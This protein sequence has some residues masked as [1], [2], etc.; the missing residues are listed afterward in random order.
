MAKCNECGRF[1]A[2]RQES[3]ESED[4]VNLKLRS[5]S[6]KNVKP[7]EHMWKMGVT[8][9]TALST[10]VIKTPKDWSSS[11]QQSYSENLTSSTEAVLEARGGQHLSNTLNVVLL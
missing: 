10:I 8:R 3:D 9:Y 6:S 11:C 1:H 5:S 4:D 7:A 2:G